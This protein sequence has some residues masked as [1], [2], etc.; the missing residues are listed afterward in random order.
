M[1]HPPAENRRENGAARSER[2]GGGWIVTLG[3]IMGRLAAPGFRRLGQCLPGVLEATF[4]G[5]EASVAVGVAR[6]GGHARFVTA[7]PGNALADACL[8]TLRGH[9]VDT[10]AIV[11]RAGCRLGLYF[12]EAGVNQRAGQVIYDREHSAFALTPADAYDWAAVFE[13]AEWFVISG[14][15]PALT[16]ATAEVAR[17]AV[18]EAGT[19]GVRVALDVNYRSKLWAWDPERP[20]RALASATLRDLMPGVD[21]LIGA[22]GDAGL[23]VDD[24]P[25]TEDTSPE[26]AEAR[27][28]ALSRAYPNLRQVALTMRA[29]PLA[30]STEFGGLLFDAESGGFHHAP[31]RGVFHS[32]PHIVDRLG[33]GDAFTAGLVFA[34]TTPPLPPPA[35]AIAFA[36]AAGGL[37][38]S[39]EGDFN[40]ATRTEIDAL[41]SG[42]SSSRIRR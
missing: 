3:E 42:S 26:A 2:S 10:H 1:T 17:T 27:A 39:I 36:T 28:V 35:A 33:A 13:G 8:A 41:I 11:R 6:L 34:L 20:P 32:I 21:L 5:A 29:G 15:T 19:R 22:P 12:V 24:V 38:H 4:A 23:L 25:D 16:E 30:S 37:A 40:L 31:A 7:L 18:R 9:G 14:I